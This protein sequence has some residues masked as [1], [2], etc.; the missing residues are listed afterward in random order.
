MFGLLGLMA[1]GAFTLTGCQNAVQNEPV[2]CKVI[3]KDRSTS[4]EGNS[5][6]RIYTEGGEKCTTFGLADNWFKGNFNSADMYGEIKV[7]ETYTFE[8]VGVRNGLLSL[9]PEI[10]S[11]EKAN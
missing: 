7:D 1:V 3:D 11:F 9:F 10:V 4:K 6:F 8:T 5:V 2:V